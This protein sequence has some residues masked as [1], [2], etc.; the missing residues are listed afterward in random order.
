MHPGS[1]MYREHNH[2][3]YNDR[4]YST[5]IHTLLSFMRR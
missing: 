2:G 5:W 4:I 1:H 3:I